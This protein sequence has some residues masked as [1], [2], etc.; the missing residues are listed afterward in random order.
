M[1][2]E[3]AAD[4]GG[5]SA[6][7]PDP[8]RLD[9][10]LPRFLDNPLARK[11]TSDGAE[12]AQALLEFIAESGDSDRI[13]VAAILLFQLDPRLF[14][15][16]FLH[17]LAGYPRAT[18]EAL[19]PGLWHGAPDQ[20]V[21]AADIVQVTRTS[22]NDDPLLLLQ[23]PAARQVREA[24]TD[25]IVLRRMPAS[26]Y[27]LYALG[28]TLLPEDQGFLAETAR[29]EDQP[30]LAALAGLYLAQLGFASDARQGIRA[31][32]TAAD[33]GLRERTYSA[34]NNLLSEAAFASACYRPSSDPREQMP[35]VE[36]L[37]NAL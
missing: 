4:L 19:A 12:S 6:D 29:A 10:Q 5:L 23:H 25:L 8:L 31:G 24:L 15:Q 9:A 7:F 28:Y 33:R 22:G 26:L 16:N 21:L 32:L 1:N 3:L 34:L 11:W 27:A 13:R 17:D 20:A 35:A 36:A 2:Q 14:Y 37:L 30:E 18:I